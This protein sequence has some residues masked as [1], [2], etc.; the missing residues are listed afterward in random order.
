MAQGQPIHETGDG[1]IEGFVFISSDHV[2]C[3]GDFD[4][5]GAGDQPLEV[6]GR[7]AGTRTDR[8]A[9]AIRASMPAAA[10]CFDAA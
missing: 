5:M 3:I 9:A 2:P 8:A 1:F 10:R 7:C 6:E 4:R